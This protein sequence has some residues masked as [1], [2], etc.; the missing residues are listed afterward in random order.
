MF[1]AMFVVYPWFF[2]LKECGI[3][4]DN[5]YQHYFVYSDTYQGS[6]LQTI[7]GSGLFIILSW[8][9]MGLVLYIVKVR[10]FKKFRSQTM[11][12]SVYN[13]I[14]SILY[15]VFILT[16]GYEVMVVMVAISV[17]IYI[18]SNK[19]L[20]G[21]LW[22]IEIVLGLMSLSYGHCM[23]L[24]QEHN[25]K[26]YVKWLQRWYKWKLYYLC[27][28]DYLCCCGCK[29]GMIYEIEIHTKEIEIREGKTESLNGSKE[30]EDTHPSTKLEPI[31]IGAVD[32]SMPTLDSTKL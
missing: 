11:D 9:F 29:D 32:Y 14:M 4:A 15:R 24:M 13:R 6:H 10:S 22:E 28:C 17:P 8:D 18:L 19:H 2:M 5:G 12:K 21:S 26:E 23:F 3:D 20:I 27:C 30:N 31:Q 7:G 16:M 1:V 25:T